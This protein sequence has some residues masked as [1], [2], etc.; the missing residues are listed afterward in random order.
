M[1]CR[2]ATLRQHE[3]QCRVQRILKMKIT[4]SIKLLALWLAFSIKYEKRVVQPDKV[5]LTGYLKARWYSPAFWIYAIL[6][7]P[8]FMLI[9]GLL[10]WID[11][12][13]GQ[14]Q[15]AT[16]KKEFWANWEKPTLSK[17]AM[18]KIEYITM[19]LL[20]RFSFR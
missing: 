8:Y 6:M 10:A 19:Y 18:F 4:T 16:F 12:L 13:I 2:R 9:G 11:W 15:Q 3:R 20:S 7:I 5:A 1:H 14:F 17:W